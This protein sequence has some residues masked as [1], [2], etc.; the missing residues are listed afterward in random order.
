[1]IELEFGQ[2]YTRPFVIALGFFDCMHLGHC[3]LLSTAKELAKRAGCEVAMFTFSNNHF[4]TLGIPSK[5]L[6][7]YEER[8]MIFNS[9]NVDITMYARFDSS[10]MRLSAKK[11]A[12]TLASY[13][14]K[15]LV[16]GFDYT[17]GCDKLNGEYLVSRFDK[18]PVEIV[19]EVSVDGVKVSS[20]LVKEL[21]R[22]NRIE[23]AN[24][25]L[26]ENFFFCGKVVHGRQVGQKIG[27]P[28]ANI[29]TDK[30]KFLP[31]G[32]YSAR[33]TVKGETYKA[34]VNIGQKPT[35]D[36]NCNTVEAHLLD[37]SDDIYGET[38][39][40]SLCGFLRD[41]VKFSSATEL[42]RQLSF[43]KARVQND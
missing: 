38:I 36:E 23:E 42:S 22:E 30:D 18:I 1:M 37:F 5:I 24:A 19:E 21:I 7:T 6:Y 4:S 27:F 34:I 31:K 32:V 14:L 41:I 2:R 39:K 10:L 29:D 25:L 16:C 40:V 20:T 3:S 33:V 35:F 13:N 9:L 15:G 28:T 11:F 26:S 17:F 12:D 8:K 43:D